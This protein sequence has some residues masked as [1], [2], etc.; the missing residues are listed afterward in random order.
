MRSGGVIFL[1][2]LAT[3]L[4]LFGVLMLGVSGL[5][6]AGP[7]FTI[8]VYSDSD[9]AERS[10]GITMGV[11]ALVAWLVLM[12]CAASVGLGS[13]HDAQDRRVIVWILV[14]M[15]AVLVLGPLVAVLSTPPPASE[16]PLPEWNRA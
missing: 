3:L 8:I 5:T 2:V 16:Y 12:L 15:G 4:G 13:G 6:M 9:D 11:M 10:I 1:T 14:G 7:G